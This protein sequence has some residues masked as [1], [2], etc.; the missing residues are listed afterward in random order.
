MTKKFK[1]KIPITLRVK[2]CTGKKDELFR[3]GVV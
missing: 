1:R 2:G 3:E